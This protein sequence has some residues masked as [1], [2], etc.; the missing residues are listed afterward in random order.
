MPFLGTRAAA[1]PTEHVLVVGGT[2]R[3]GRRLVRALLDDSRFEVTALVRDPEKA[4]LTF[5]REA[6]IEGRLNVVQGDLTDVESWERE[7]KGVSQVVTAVSCGLCTDPLVVLGVREPPAP[8]PSAVDGDGISRLA[9]AAKAH[10]VRR[11]VAVTTASAG[12][13]WS[14][15]AL[16][17]N[18]YHF[19]SV[20]EKWRGEQAIRRSGLD[21]VILRPYG[22]G[23]DVPPPPGER[24]VEWSQNQSPGGARRRI[25]R[26]DV[27]RLCLEALLLPA[28]VAARATFECWASDEH[29]R[30]MEWGALRS[31]PPGA[32]PAVD[33]TTAVA[34]AVGGTAAVGAAG[35]RGAWRAGRAALRLL[36]R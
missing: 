8:L 4:E 6:E 26:E 32:L 7:L 23:R 27:A 12:S 1:A 30:P 15:A 33:H 34:V 25:P 10:G 20:R 3:T 31:D 17:L 24:G 18:A 16:F 19:F 35:V 13:P 5:G 36:A 2:G 21:Y 9:S 14:P 11:F 28:G 29:A 22:L